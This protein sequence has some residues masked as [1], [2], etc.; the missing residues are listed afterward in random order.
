MFDFIAKIVDWLVSFWR[1][2]PPEAKEKII[3]LAVDAFESMFR[4][5]FRSFQEE[6]AE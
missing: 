1:D 6:K 4:A 2:L 5:F 3:N